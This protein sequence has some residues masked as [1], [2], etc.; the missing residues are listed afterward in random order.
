MIHFTS[1]IF[2]YLKKLKALAVQNAQND[3]LI[4][5]AEKLKAEQHTLHKEFYALK[6]QID[7]LEDPEGSSDDD[8]GNSW[9]YSIYSQ[10]NGQDEVSLYD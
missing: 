8:P 6:K 3:R 5:R 10:I 1:A 4:K 7:S 2:D 9:P